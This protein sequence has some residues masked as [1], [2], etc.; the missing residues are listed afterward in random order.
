MNYNSEINNKSNP[1]EYKKAIVFDNSGTLIERYK[2]IKDIEN[3]KII[4][5]INP[6]TLIDNLGDSALAVLQCN[7]NIL[8][9]LNQDMKIS[10][11]IDK[12]NVEIT[13]SYSSSDASYD[14]L[15]NI[16]KSDDAVI[17][18]IVDCFEP[19]KKKVPK[20]ELC[21]GSALILDV[22]NKKVDYTI[23][24]AGQL[25]PNVKSTISKL[26]DKNIQVFIA[27]G[28]RYGALLKLGELLNINKENIFPT[29]TKKRKGEIISELQ[30]EGYKVMMVGD[31]PNDIVAFNNA[32]VATLT[33]EQKGDYGDR[34][35]KH[36]DFII[37]NI[38][39]VL[40]I[41]F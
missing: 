16:I 28:D 6:M 40:D 17:S 35:T 21:N 18:E 4:T 14:E 25:F 8:K 27:S 22:K 38:E 24:S 11:F 36:A 7:T 29:P 5:H 30:N 2:A 34:M 23:T 37:D 9:D 32:D 26:I 31:G 19:L 33:I 10:E 20:I 39:K 13:V 12:Y 15:I 41:D 3:N 1:K